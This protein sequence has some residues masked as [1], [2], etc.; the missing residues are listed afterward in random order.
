MMCRKRVRDKVRC[1]RLVISCLAAVVI[2]AFEACEPGVDFDNP[3]DEH[4]PS[5]NPC[6]SSKCNPCLP[7]EQC[8]M[9]D[10]GPQCACKSQLYCG[11]G[12]EKQCCPEGAVCFQGGCCLP[13]CDG[14]EC[15]S[16][17]C[18]GMCG[19]CPQGKTCNAQ[20]GKCLLCTCNGRE[21]GDDGCGNSCGECPQH[22]SC[23]QNGHCL[24]ER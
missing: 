16:D 6:E 4:S 9:G 13:D 17:G 7:G 14:R 11:A 23:D 15:G 3:C 18:G 20:T 12:T 1:A 2:L 24:L 19:E 21:C 5:Y 22:Y 8:N 10:A